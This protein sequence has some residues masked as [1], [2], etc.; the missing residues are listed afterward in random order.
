M[1]NSP[2]SAFMD[3]LRKPTLLTVSNPLQPRLL[4]FQFLFN[5]PPSSPLPF[6]PFILCAKLLSNASFPL[7][8]SFWMA[9]RFGLSLP[10]WWKRHSERKSV[11]KHKAIPFYCSL[12]FLFSMMGSWQHHPV[13]LRSRA[14][15]VTDVIPIWNNCEHLHCWY[16]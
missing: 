15:K 1:P 4:L 16:K 5:F 3:S 9:Q 7:Y 10:V 14:G 6:P 2:L 11:H 8:L 12:T 13:I